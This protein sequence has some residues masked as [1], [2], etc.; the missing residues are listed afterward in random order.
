MGAGVS[1][2]WSA[3]NRLKWV[4]IHTQYGLRDFS[5]LIA[6]FEPTPRRRLFGTHS[7]VVLTPF[8]AFRCDWRM[9]GFQKAPSTFSD[10]GRG[11]ERAG[12]EATRIGD[13]IRY[14]AA[15]VFQIEYAS[16]SAMVVA[17]TSL[18]SFSSMA[19]ESQ[20]PIAPGL[21]LPPPMVRRW[22]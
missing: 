3:I 11:N 13:T 18:L 16:T 19:S 9:G 20:S 15:S 5:H 10:Y 8:T 14:V 12:Q 1:G 22:V 7:L 21:M 6:N 4:A 2:R 17:V